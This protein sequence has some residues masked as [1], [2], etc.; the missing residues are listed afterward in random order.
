MRQ[1]LL[2]AGA[3]FAREAIFFFGR[4][5]TPRRS[6]TPAALCLSRFKMDALL[7]KRFVDCGG[8]LQQ[9]KACRE[10]HFGEGVVRASGRCIQP[11]DNGWRWFGLKVHARNVNLGA[12]LEMHCLTNRYVGMNRVEE[13]K[14]NVCGLFRRGASSQESPQTW[15]AL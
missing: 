3:T 6:I 7:A 4:A 5:A 15:Q 13:G 14:V 12:D 8:E 9:K 1:L 2:D 10:R 11:V